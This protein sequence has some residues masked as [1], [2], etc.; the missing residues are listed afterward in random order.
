VQTKN[1]YVVEQEG[2]GEKQLSVD[3]ESSATD[4]G[5]ASDNERVSV[6]RFCRALSTT[7]ADGPPGQELKNE[8]KELKHEFQKARN[9]LNH[10]RG[11][12]PR[13]VARSP[14]AGSAALSSSPGTGGIAGPGAGDERKK[15][16]AKMAE[17]VVELLVYTVGVKCRGLNKK[18]VY[19]P[20]HMFSLSEKTADK[21]MHQGPLELIKHNRTHLVRIYPKGMRFDS[22]NYH[23]HRFWAVGAQ[24]VALNWQTFGARVA[25]CVRTMADGAERRPWNAHQSRHVPA[26][27]AHRVRAQAP[28]A[29]RVEQGA[30]FE[31]HAP[32]P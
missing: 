14:P 17:E 2:S 5:S 28:R 22:S 25:G 7:P 9:I 8:V 11:K 27:R 31:A 20:E 13:P 16:K 10:V 12:S 19:A 1:V 3:T 29:A 23:P 21:F 30:T 15:T 4:T 6:G 32:L 24:L 18:E 26:Q